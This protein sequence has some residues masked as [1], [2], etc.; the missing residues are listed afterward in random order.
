MDLLLKY[1]TG[2]AQTSFLAMWSRNKERMEECVQYSPLLPVMQPLLL[3][4]AKAN[5]RRRQTA[6]NWPQVAV[7]CILAPL[8]ESRQTVPVERRLWP[9]F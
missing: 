3:P 9:G 8:A 5:A 7:S 1:M 2:S 4:F 6:L